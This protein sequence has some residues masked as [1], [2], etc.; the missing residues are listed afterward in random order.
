MTG[1]DNEKPGL[2][3]EAGIG[4]LPSPFVA[5]CEEGS[6]LLHTLT[7]KTVASPYFAADDFAFAYAKA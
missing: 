4:L 7:G 5:L 1:L 6:K 3:R 2:M